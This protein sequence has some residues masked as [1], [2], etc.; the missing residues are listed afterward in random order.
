MTTLFKSLVF[1]CAV[2]AALPTLAADD[3]ET[4][5]INRMRGFIELM[6]GFYGI[7]ETT[8]MI[9]DNPEMSAVLQMH[10]IEEIYKERGDR[11]KAIAE[12]YAVL[13]KTD[14]PTIRNT[15]YHLLGEA[16]K[17]TGRQEEAI[18][19]LK[20]GLEENIKLAE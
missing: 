16:L 7:I 13:E 6:H 14:N 1:A 2:S 17:E 11:S 5:H 15:A 19:V 4:Q 9:A 3:A 8:H 12:F 20:K 10:K 18:K